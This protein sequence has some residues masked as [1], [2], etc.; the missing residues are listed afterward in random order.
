[1]Q[2]HESD[3][4]R[5]KAHTTAETLGDKFQDTLRKE[6]CRHVNYIKHQYIA[7]SS[8]KETSKLLF[9]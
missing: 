5:D 6:T 7:L 8:L 1:M 3:G 9:T 2:G 4:S